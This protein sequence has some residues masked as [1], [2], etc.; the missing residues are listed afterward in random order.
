MC[1]QNDPFGV[2]AWQWK[3]HHSRRRGGPER[4]TARDA[5]IAKKYSGKY[6]LLAV[7]PNRGESTAMQQQAERGGRL[8]C[9]KGKGKRALAIVLAA[10]IIVAPGSGY[11]V[12]YQGCKHWSHINCVGSPTKEF[13]CCHCLFLPPVWSLPASSEGLY[14]VGWDKISRQTF[15]EPH[16][17]EDS[18]KSLGWEP[19][20]SETVLSAP[21]FPRGTPGVGRATVY[22]EAYHPKRRE[23]PVVSPFGNLKCPRFEVIGGMIAG[24]FKRSRAFEGISRGV[25]HSQPPHFSAFPG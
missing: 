22:A 25:S 13:T 10:P 12:K 19:I 5:V 1:K 21:Y 20:P 17:Q 8:D 14:S 7:W 2:W 6:R 23:D 4:P 9:H 3:R 18:G 11:T 15:P 16:M 24:I